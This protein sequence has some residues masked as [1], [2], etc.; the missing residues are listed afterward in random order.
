MPS[1]RAS[2]IARRPAS[3]VRRSCEIQATSSRRDDSRARSR[4]REAASLALVVAN[5]RPSSASSEVRA[6]CGGA[7]GASPPASP[8]ARVAA[9][10][11]RLPSTTRRPSS[12]ATASETTAAI[13]Q[14]STTTRRSCED[15]NIAHATDSVPASIAPTVTAATTASDSATDRCRSNR[16]AYAPSNPATVA[17][18]AAYSAMTS[19]SRMAVPPFLSR[20]RSRRA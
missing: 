8:S 7:K 16:R 6:P 5:S 1:S 18:A 14:T 11:A 20:S 9:A 15:R 10:S 2:A 4:S 12:S 3:G 17:P 13:A 19:R